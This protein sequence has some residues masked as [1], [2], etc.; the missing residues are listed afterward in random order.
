MKKI[1]A[2]KGWRITW[3]NIDAGTC[4]ND[5]GNPVCPPSIVLCSECLDGL[6]E[7]L[8][9]L[10]ARLES[11]PMPAEMRNAALPGRGLPPEENP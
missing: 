10:L 1:P 5:D 6:G 8:R 4:A 9:G 7:K 2:R 3:K 11:R